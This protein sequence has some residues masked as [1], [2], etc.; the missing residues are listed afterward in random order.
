MIITVF[1][2]I[3]SLAGIAGF[4]YSLY[5]A[6][7]QAWA[8]VIE[9]TDRHMKPIAGNVDSWAVARV[10]P[11]AVHKDV[12]IASNTLLENFAKLAEGNATGLDGRGKIKQSGASRRESD[13]RVE[14]LDPCALEVMPV[15]GLACFQLRVTTAPPWSL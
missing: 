1:P 8:E 10:L 7:R 12:T 4:K 6:R 9:Q 3:H 13:S 2:D 5:I 14:S 11:L 15:Q